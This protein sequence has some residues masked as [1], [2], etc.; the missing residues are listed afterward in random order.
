MHSIFA[1]GSE[2]N[3][4]SE[5]FYAFSS[6]AL[7]R[8]TAFLPTITALPRF[9]AFLPAIATLAP[10]QFSKFWR[11]WQWLL[12]N[13]LVVLFV[14]RNRR[15]RRYIADGECERAGG[16]ETRN[17]LLLQRTQSRHHAQR[18]G[19]LRE[20]FRK[21]VVNHNRQMQS[22]AIP[23]AGQ[24]GEQR[25]LG[26][27]YSEQST[28]GLLGKTSLLMCGYMSNTERS[29][30]TCIAVSF[31]EN[32]TSFVFSSDSFRR[33]DWREHDLALQSMSEG[34]KRGET[35]GRR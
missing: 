21:R 15:H 11:K 23:E 9:T 25:V 32:T 22:A 18:E 3:W 31:V 33:R 17:A 6:A 26:L 2:S 10:L 28:Q 20:V 13:T 12:P 35:V 5:R 19:I 30:F 4:E 34:C 16:D 8:V 24:L 27:N 1:Y 29:N 14:P 7:P